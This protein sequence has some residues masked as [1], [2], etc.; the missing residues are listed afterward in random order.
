MKTLPGDPFLP[1]G[2]SSR[3]VAN[4]FGIRNFCESCGFPCSRQE[5]MCRSCQKKEEYN[6][7]DSNDLRDLL[8][9]D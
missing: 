7:I 3:D 9:G 8:P 5:T 4:S 1:P 2:C 6:D